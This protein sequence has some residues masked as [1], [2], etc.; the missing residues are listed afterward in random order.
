MC[1]VC[2]DK[3]EGT[4]MTSNTKQPTEPCWVCVD[5]LM[6]LANGETD[7]EWSAEQKAEFLA[8]VK[9]GQGD[10]EVTLGM[11]AKYHDCT[12]DNQGEIADECECE[13]NS[14]SWS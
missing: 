6:L 1:C 13:Q 4:A 3:R 8:R 9:R 2:L 12:D 10:A 14:F 11:L 5:C 7:P